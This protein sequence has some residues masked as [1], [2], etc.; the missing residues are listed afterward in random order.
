MVVV[1]TWDTF[2]SPDTRALSGSVNISDRISWLN[3]RVFAAYYNQ[4]NVCNAFLAGSRGVLGIRM[5][6]FLCRGW[7]EHLQCGWRMLICWDRYL[8]LYREHLA[9][10]DYRQVTGGNYFLLHHW[11]ATSSISLILLDVS[12][13]IKSV[14]HQTK[15]PRN[16]HKVQEFKSCRD[17]ITRESIRARNEPGFYLAVL[18]NLI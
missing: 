9:D 13:V 14:S 7:G 3:P 18:I 5:D 11:H 10:P 12:A 8:L 1:K 17:T 6:A 4:L 2:S 16:C 15:K